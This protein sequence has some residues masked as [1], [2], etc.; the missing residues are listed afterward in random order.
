MSERFWEQVELLMEKY[1]WALD[2]RGNLLSQRTSMYENKIED[3]RAP[4]DRCTEF[5]DCTKTKMDHPSGYR[6][7]QRSACS[8]HD[9]CH[10]L[11]YQSLT[12]LDGVI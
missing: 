2:L 9:Q 11:I 5:V 4:L 6:S 12:T 10:C 8:E 7:L 1:S 3:A